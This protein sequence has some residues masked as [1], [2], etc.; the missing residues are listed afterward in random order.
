MK[1][2]LDGFIAGSIDN[3]ESSPARTSVRS[4][5][6]QSPGGGVR[7]HT[8]K[9]GAKTPPSTGSRRP[10]SR[11]RPRTP[12]SPR[13]S[14]GPNSP[15]SSRPAQD[16]I[17]RRSSASS[18]LSS[19]GARPS[20][21]PAQRPQSPRRSATP[22]RPSSRQRKQGGGGGATGTTSIAQHR[23]SKRGL[24]RSAAGN[25]SGSGPYSSSTSADS[26]TSSTGVHPPSAGRSGHGSASKSGRGVA[27]RHGGPS[28]Q[29]RVDPPPLPKLAFEEG[30][31]EVGGLV[32]PQK[33]SSPDAGPSSA[34]VPA[35][36]SSKPP[37]AMSSQSAASASG[38]E[39]SRV[40]DPDGGYVQVF[41]R[42]RYVD[43]QPIAPHPSPPALL[44]AFMS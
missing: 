32:Q 28:A 34:V 5:T 13:A 2:L 22:T 15:R 36:Q 40:F 25:T 6:K 8:R 3:V 33:S 11:S 9:K 17:P 31:Q 39:Y 42:C 14:R 29:Q 18:A 43:C 7:S 1:T 23:S 38:T 12:S 24:P 16:S 41:I 10:R 26:S 21:P 19:P 4:G 27:P 35:P 44:E 30:G 20:T 37:Q